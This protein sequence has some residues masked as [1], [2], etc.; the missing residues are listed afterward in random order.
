VA[1]SAPQLPPGPT[2]DNTLDRLVAKPVAHPAGQVLNKQIKAWRTKFFVF[3]INRE[4]S[5]TNNTFEREIRP[6]VVFRKVTN[7][8]RSDWATQIRAGYRSVT[9]TAHLDDQPALRAI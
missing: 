2:A 4:V 8:F 9:S 5:A 7:G 1:T 6:S 3:L